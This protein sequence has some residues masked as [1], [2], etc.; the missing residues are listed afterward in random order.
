[1]CTTTDSVL[2]IVTFR[3]GQL[4]FVWGHPLEITAVS[5]GPL[6]LALKGLQ[7]LPARQAGSD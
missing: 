3:V 2:C 5:G 7:Q 1:M 6:Q 4:Q